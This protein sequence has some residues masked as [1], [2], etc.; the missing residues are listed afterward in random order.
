MLP[1]DDR[2]PSRLPHP[3]LIRPIERF[4]PGHDDLQALDCP[5]DSGDVGH[6]DV[7]V[8]AS[9]RNVSHGGY[10]LPNA[11]PALVHHLDPVLLEDH[12]AEPVA[13]GYLGDLGEAQSIHHEGETGLDRIDHEDWGKLVEFDRG[14]TYLR[15]EECLT[16]TL[17]SSEPKTGRLGDLE[18]SRR[19]A[20]QRPGVSPVRL[21]NSVTR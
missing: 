21:R 9:G 10:V 4:P 8:G 11:L 7:Q 3:D 16:T 17:Y 15:K 19:E 14:H 13:F 5:L 18:P 6:V 12:E 20:I 1:K 2:V